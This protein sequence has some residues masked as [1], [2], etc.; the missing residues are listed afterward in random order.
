[1]DNAPPTTTT[2]K[3]EFLQ[4]QSLI[5]STTL[6]PSQAFRD[7]NKVAE[8]SLPDRLIDQVTQH[9]DSQVQLHGKRVLAPQANRAVAEQISDRYIKDVERRMEREALAESGIRKDADLADQ[10]VIATLP[11]T[12]SDEKEVSSRPTEAKRYADAVQQLLALNQQRSELKQRVERLRNMKTTID[13]LQ[14]TEGGAGIQEN[15]VT[16]NGEME[17][18]LEKMRILLA[19]VAGRVGALPDKPSS[20]NNDTDLLGGGMKRSIDDF[21]ND[22]QVFPRQ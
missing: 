2:L 7:A 16:R 13:P 1:M 15:L 5:L 8:G 19:R 18:E 9:V 21:L 4:S 17:K 22:P 3:E 10:A 20:R 6:V 11:E 14:T 12:W